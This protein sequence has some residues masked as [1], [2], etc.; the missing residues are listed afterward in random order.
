MNQGSFPHLQAPTWANAAVLLSDGSVFWGCGL[1]ATGEACGELCFNTS[2][3]GYQEVLSDPSYAGQI[4][5]FTFPHVGNVGVTTADMESEA[6]LARGVVLRL[7]V[8]GPSSWRCEGSL[9]SWLLAHGIV[10]IAGVDTRALTTRIRDRGAMSGSIVFR[11]RQKDLTPEVLLRAGRT[12]REWPGLRGMDLASD[13]SPSRKADRSS[14]DSNAAGSMSCV[15]GRT[16]PISQ[17]STSDEGLGSGLRVALVDYGAKRSIARVLKHLGCDV[18]IFPARAS[19]AE[20]SAF[21]P[22]GVVLSNGPGDPAACAP[23]ATPVLQALLERRDLPIFGICL[24]HQ[25]LA[26]ALG[27]KTV[28]LPFGHRGANHPVLDLTTRRVIISSQNHGFAVCRESF[29][30]GVE[31]SHVSLFDSSNEG[32]RLRSR[33]VFSVQY[34]PEASPGPQDSLGLF[35]DFV[36][37]MRASGL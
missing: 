22:C 4:V 20:I 10:G 8:C 33:P 1:G 29:P 3:S 11:S 24:G 17:A 27:A 6:P 35:A 13:A 14:T 31:E 2:V 25:L 15:R 7:S 16:S 21:R 19:A 36:R 32:L 12:I 30:A 9:P 23:W 18:G 34:H 5:V 26:L 28:K 37:M